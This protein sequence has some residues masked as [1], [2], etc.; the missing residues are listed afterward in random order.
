MQQTSVF[1][2]AS[3]LCK[4]IIDR[5]VLHFPHHRF[6]FV[7]ARALDRLQI[8][9]GGGIDARLHHGRHALV[10]VK[11][12]FRPGA[13]RVAEIPVKTLG[14]VH[15]ACGFQRQAVH[16]GNEHQQSGQRLFWSNPEF[17][18]LLDRIGGI[19]AGIGEPDHLGARGLRLQQERGEI[20]AGKR[21]AHRTE[22]L[23]AHRG[24][25]VAGVLFQRMPESIIRRQ[26][27]PGI[28]ALFHHCAPGADGQRRGVVGVVDSQVGAGLAGDVGRSGTVDDGHPVHLLGH[29]HH[30]KRGGRGH[31]IA[32]H[33]HAVALEPLAGLV[34]GHVALVLVVRRNQLNL[35]RI[36]FLLQKIINRHARGDQRSLAR[37]VGISTRQIGQDADLDHAAGKFGLLRRC[38][39]HHPQKCSGD[40]HKHQIFLHDQLLP[41]ID[42][43]TESDTQQFM[44]PPHA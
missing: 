18:R 43:T 2:N 29:R 20:R 26:E 42:E 41:L 12:A 34:R 31:Q 9:H 23:A 37:Q 4:K 40:C 3:V 24:H 38:D 10:L 8:M 21:M 27:K 22:H 15:A 33:V 30:G 36:L 28:A 5:R 19:G 35:E 44:Q 17:R 1:A 14:Q 11:E 6:C 39:C 25:H 16:V 13:G 32:D 7:G